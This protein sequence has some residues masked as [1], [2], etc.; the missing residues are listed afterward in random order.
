MSFMSILES[1]FI[2]PLKLIFEVIFEIANRFVNHPGLSI[3]FLSLIM[4]ILVL[5]LYRRA[6]AMQEEARDTDLRL[7]KGVEHIKKTFSG[8][9][10]M[11][12]MQA[13]YRQNNYKPTDALKGSV[14][15][16]LEIPFFMAAYQFL[17]NL[18][19]IEGVSLG[20]IQDLSAPD[21][22]LVIGGIAINLLPVLMTLINFISSAL[23]LKGFP[24]KTKIQLYG[25]AVFFLVF[26]YKSPAGLVFYWTLNNLFSLVK[27]IFYKIKN[28]KKVL[29]YLLA[30]IGLGLTVF[31]VGFYA[32]PT[33][34][35]KVFV[36]A[37]GVAL[38]LPLVLS[39]RKPKETNRPARALPAPSKKLFLVSGLFLT[40]LMGLLIPATF[41]AASPQEYVDITYFQHPLWYIV[42]SLCM[43][44]GA[45]L[46]WLRVFY[47]LANDKGKV[48]FERLL[49]AFCGIAFVNYMFF[50]TKLGIISSSLQY[51]NG[52]DFTL[53][54]QAANLGVLLV[55]GAALVLC[56]IKWRKA[57]IAVISVAAV[58]FCAMSGL[59]VVTIK[60]SVDDISV[61]QTSKE[62]N[63]QLT[64]N[65]KNVM[66][67]MMDR[68]FGGYVPHLMKEDPNL[69]KQFAGFTYYSNVISFGGS[70]NFGVP[71]L[72]GGY[73]YTP[74]EMNKR[75]TELLVTK[76]NEALKLMPELFEKNG[77]QVTVSDPPYANYSEIPDL[78]IFDE[79]PN[80]NTFI[81]GARFTDPAL[82]AQVVKNSLRNFF[83]FSVMKSM[84][85]AAQ[86]TIYNNG[87]YNQAK[88]SAKQTY[89]TQNAQSTSVASGIS[90]GFM[91]CYNVLANLSN[92]TKVTDEEKNTFMIFTNN[93]SHEPTL[94]QTPD[95]VPAMQVDNTAY[96]AA[97]TDR[98]T[99]NGKTMK[100]DDINKMQH[101]HSNMATFKQLGAWFDD[102]RKQ[103]VYDNT[104][105]ILVADH[106]R[107]LDHFDELTHELESGRINTEV[108]YPLLMVKD[109]G[110]TEF[111]TSDKFMTNADVPTL[112]TEGIIENPVNP[113]T[114]KAINS[115]EKTAHDQYMIISGKWRITENNG[116]TY[117]PAFWASVKDNL[118][119]PDNWA[120][121]K[122][123]DVVLKEHAFPKK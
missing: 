122:D 61:E 20:P 17:S 9:E 86:P 101:Y 92:I 50:G 4:N 80:M 115:D 117:L 22:L 76:H 39:F 78:S 99:A 24:L 49:V 43:A 27:T 72:F 58:A 93:T 44:I 16:L 113:F 52:M 36:I 60:Q 74:V 68:A 114:G 63:F 119:D 94:L 19:T 109:F 66:V 55:V 46:V 35:K 41:I 62:P 13:Y 34:K 85:L 88:S 21:G 15:L 25:M 87:N 23:Y 121:Y 42:S 1:V 100:V 8:D 12:I 32:A 75:D 83:C 57:A 37:V 70:T 38:L 54:Q 3:I 110:S 108:Y 45:F 116:K 71:A 48:I 91:A 65:G 105:I 7:S 67:I 107:G 28:P 51:E 118:W 33:L 14:S 30:V 98:F 120:M 59:H 82:K 79:Y 31:G 96:D 73:E 6:D 104:R 123:E 89:S 47:W 2:G 84:P 106:G 53:L 40:A 11:M 103:G 29:S 26:L 56:V 95:Y 102:L 10:K 112:A 18:K 81:T 77:Y 69:K 90:N 111:T 97:N 5:P 64:T